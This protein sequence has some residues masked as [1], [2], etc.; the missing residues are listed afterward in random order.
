MNAFQLHTHNT[1]KPANIG[2]SKASPNEGIFNYV[3]LKTIESIPWLAK[4]IPN[5]FTVI[6]LVKL[7]TYKF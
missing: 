4:T 2:W 7:C 1:G 6:I 3:L 5:N